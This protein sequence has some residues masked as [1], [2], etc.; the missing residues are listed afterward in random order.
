MLVEAG[1][2]EEA[3]LAFCL[4]NEVCYKRYERSSSVEED[5]VGED[6]SWRRVGA[7]LSRVLVIFPKENK[8]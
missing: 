1:G 5:S 2:R 7:S 6:G 4:P 3:T 8:G